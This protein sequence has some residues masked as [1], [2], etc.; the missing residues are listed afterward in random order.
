VLG[1]GDERRLPGP[2]ESKALSRQTLEHRG[3][4]QRP[5]SPPELGV[6]GLE[7]LSTSLQ[8]GKLASFP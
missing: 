2:H 1:H 5:N 6:L 8:T 4:L 3:I 7:L